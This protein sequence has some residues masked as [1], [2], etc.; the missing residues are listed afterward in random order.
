MP[1]VLQRFRHSR[2]AAL[3][4]VACFALAWLVVARPVLPQLLPA[5]VICSAGG[6]FVAEGAAQ[7]GDAAQGQVH[8]KLC[9]MSAA[10]L[11][12]P[13]LLPQPAPAPAGVAPLA[14]LPAPG[15]HAALPAPARGPP[16]GI[17]LPT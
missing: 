5:D 12:P 8:C 14:L 6:A 17:R 4:W 10:L 3:L 1:P 11:P 16:P 13:L 7:H 9:T 2:R 15:A